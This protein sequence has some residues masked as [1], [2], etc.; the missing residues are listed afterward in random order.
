MQKTRPTKVKNFLIRATAVS[1]LVASLVGVARAGQGGVDDATRAAAQSFEAKL[2]NLQSG[3][4]APAASYPPVT[5]TEFEANSYLKLHSGEFLPPGVHNPAVQFQPQHV[6]GSADVNFEEFSRANTNPNDWGPKVLAA[7]FKGTQ[8]VTAT[9]KVESAQG[10]AHVQIESVA[11]GSMNVP[12]WLVDY[13]IQNVLQPKY[14]FDLSKPIALPN[15]VT[16]IV[17]GTRQATFLR[18]AVNPH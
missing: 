12:D 2:Q 9:A 8:R 3:N 13:L 4:S 18:G 7:M 10:Q 17:L 11:V 16:Q 5:I 15:H 6:T 14:G 1:A